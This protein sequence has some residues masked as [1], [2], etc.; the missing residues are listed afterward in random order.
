MAG[1][2]DEQGA[3]GRVDG[4][5]GHDVGDRARG[6]VGRQHEGDRGRPAAVAQQRL[7]RAL[8][9]RCD[10]RRSPARRGAR[11][12]ARRRRAARRPARSSG[13]RT[14]PRRSASPETQRRA[15]NERTSGTS[16]E[17]TRPLRGQQLAQRARA[18]A[19]RVGGHEAPPAPAGQARGHR[20]GVRGHDAQH[21]AGAQQPR[22]ALDRGDGVVEV[23]ET[24]AS[25]TT[26]KPSSSAKS[27]TGCLTH[28]E[29]E[30]LAGM[31]RRRARQL[32][33]DRLV[34]ARARLVEQQPVP[35]ADVEQAPA[36]TCAAIR[37]SRRAGGG[38]PPAL[39]AEIGV[40]AHLAVELVQR[41]ARRQQRLLDGAALHARQQ[42]AVVGRSRATRARTP[43][44]PG[45]GRWCPRRAG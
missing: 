17:I 19:G 7:R 9:H 39:L 18:A 26:S 28:V 42:I 25:T 34:A 6:L 3:V 44:P 32:Q 22:A 24:S 38:A 12:S 35:A 29:A 21:A 10:E 5:L 13:P 15:E 37:S 23:L 4:D 1:V 40:V 30:R 27:S 43:R 33:A 36:A 31:A 16:V 11:G 14:G 45:R 2:V 41:V 20:G 8:R